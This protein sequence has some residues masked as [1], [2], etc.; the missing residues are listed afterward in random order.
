M[1][2]SASPFFEV[3][4]LTLCPIEDDHECD[5]PEHWSTLYHLLT[6]TEGTYTLAL[7]M[8]SDSPVYDRYEDFRLVPPITKRNEAFLAHE[9]Y[10]WER[11]TKT[12]RQRRKTEPEAVAPVV[13]I[14]RGKKGKKK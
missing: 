6:E 13:P 2:R 5:E 4:G 12:A 10:A 14:Q 11:G 7:V 9:G 3:Q 8:E 1:P